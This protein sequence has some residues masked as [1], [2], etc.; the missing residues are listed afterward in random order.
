MK[1]SF[2][3]KE[4]LL[5]IGFKKFGD[6]VLISRNA[7]FYNPENVSMGSN[8]RIDDFCI[9]SGNINLGSNIHIGAYTA[10]YGKLGF[11]MEDFTGISPRCTFFTAMDDFSGNYLISPMQPEEFTNVTGGKIIMQKFSQVGA[12]TIVF[13]NLIIAAGCVVG[14]MSLVKTSLQEWTIYAGIPVKQIKQRDKQI[15]NLV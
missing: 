7:N 15:Q 6:N 1:H 8:I 13:P 4:E 9:F 5:K 12:G 10:I 2:Y 14:A 3:S 11:I